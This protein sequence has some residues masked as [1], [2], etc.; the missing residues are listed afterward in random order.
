[1]LGQTLINHIIL[2]KNPG[3]KIDHQIIEKKPAFFNMATCHSYTRMKTFNYDAMINNT[4][5]FHFVPACRGK[6]FPK[7][8][9][10]FKESPV[11]IGILNEALK[12][13]NLVKF[14]MVLH[15]YAD[16][17]SHQGFSGLL[18]KVNDIKDCI[19]HTTVQGGRIK[20]I[21]KFFRSLFGSKF[22]RYFDKLMPAYG[23]GQAFDYPD[24][25]YLTWSYYYDYSD[26]FSSAFKHSDLID[27]KE[28]FRQAFEAIRKYLKQYLSKHSQYQD[29]DVKFND[30]DLLFSS[31]V[32]A[33]TD[34]NRIRNWQR[35]MINNNLF[36]RG[37]RQLEYKKHAWIKAAFLNFDEK[38]FDQRTVDE[39][40]L[41]PD[42]ENSLWYQYYL[43]AKWYQEEFFKH[44]KKNK[45][46]I[47]R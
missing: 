20:K 42:F 2:K 25:P 47:P 10:C 9:R 16:T 43:A 1:M 29:K 44:C 38:K 35:V 28:R 40:D 19:A 26:Q 18:C 8:L 34:E 30:F 32:K 23:H 37:D 12:D 15:P 22:D 4:S 11:I 24:L 39:V 14:G 21:I 13:S 33:D 41:L 6:S 17:F 31:L 3:K 45:L 46:I 27:N 36:S 5:A 7:M